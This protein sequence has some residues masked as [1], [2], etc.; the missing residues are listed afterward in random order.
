MRGRRPPLAV[1]APRMESP[2]NPFFRKAGAWLHRRAENVAAGLL[3]AMFIAFVLQIFFRYVFNF[4]IGWT[5]ELTVITWLWLVPF[6]A[7]R[8][9]LCSRQRAAG[10]WSQRCVRCWQGTVT[11]A[12]RCLSRCFD[13]SADC[14]CVLAAMEGGLPESSA[15]FKNPIPATRAMVLA[16][17]LVP[18]LGSF[19][20][21]LCCESSANNFICN[22][23]GGGGSLLRTP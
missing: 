17:R 11:S 23:A 4:P 8:M 2:I 1:G 6:G 18:R 10:I 13:V 16:P 5:S 19:P 20:L 21:L 15:L 22:V 7:A 3:A 9:L 14:G 12:R